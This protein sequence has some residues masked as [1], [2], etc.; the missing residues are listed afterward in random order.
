[1]KRKRRQAPQAGCFKPIFFLALKIST[2]RLDEAYAV[3]FTTV[4]CIT[5]RVETHLLIKGDVLP[6]CM[7]IVY[8][9]RQEEIKINMNKAKE[10]TPHR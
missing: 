5:L 7:H 2:L 6:I 4:H 3:W 1:M 8:S 9:Y 10:K